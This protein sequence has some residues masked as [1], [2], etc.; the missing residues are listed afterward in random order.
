MRFNAQQED[1]SKVDSLTV[2][3]SVI[4]QQAKLLPASPN[5]IIPGDWLKSKPSLVQSHMERIA[6][7]M[8][9]QKWWISSIEGLKFLDSCTEE[10]IHEVL[11][12]HFRSSSLQKEQQ[13]VKES[14]TRV[15]EMYS[16]GEL[17]IPLKR[18]KIYDS[19]GKLKICHPNSS[20]SDF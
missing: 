8:V 1:D 14:W 19:D 9:D 3:E 11:P 15:I 2:Q 10:R 12:H 20:N 13:H 7:F 5:S 4:S 16:R 6:D 18:I 17:P